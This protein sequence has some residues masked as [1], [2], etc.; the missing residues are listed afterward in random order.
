MLAKELC[1]VHSEERRHVVFPN[2]C[3]SV[4][5][6]RYFLSTII[7]LFLTISMCLCGR[8]VIRRNVL[9]L[10]QRRSSN[11]DN[12]LFVKKADKASLS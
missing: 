9:F 4:A 12:S 6:A 11:D 8:G 2:T 7:C 1:D 10:L 5:C 3:Q